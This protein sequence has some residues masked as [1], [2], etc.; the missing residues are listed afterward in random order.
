MSKA[1]GLLG[2]DEFL[3]QSDEE[4]ETYSQQF[5]RR[6]GVPGQKILKGAQ[7]RIYMHPEPPEIETETE[8]LEP[9]SAKYEERDEMLEEKIDEDTG[10]TQSKLTELVNLAETFTGIGRIRSEL[11][12]FVREMSV[13]VKPRCKDAINKLGILNKRI[14]GKSTEIINPNQRE[15]YMN[16]SFRVGWTKNGF[17]SVNRS[18][19]V[20]VHKVIIHRDLGLENLEDNNS[21]NYGKY[22]KNLS[23]ISKNLYEP[24][25]KSLVNNSAN[26]DEL[27]QLSLSESLRDKKRA[28][29]LKFPD[30]A[31]LSSALIEYV[32][33]IGNRPLFREE[34]DETKK[35]IFGELRLKD[36]EILSL[37]NTLFGQCQLD[38]WEYAINYERGQISEEDKEE[39]KVKLERSIEREKQNIFIRK[40]G[41]S[42]WLERKSGQVK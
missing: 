40:H 31:G 42:K 12:G 9:E 32:E 25:M 26:M 14:A 35:I 16:R 4:L 38:L 10:Y 39:I 37:M 34:T 22:K 30:A 29:F 18:G 20:S 23:F 3:G 33:S 21:F 15:F 36:V 27:A 11:T 7:G 17:A 2:E 19:E 41:L 13:Q 8:G 28:S 6:H 1:D 5:R 24:L